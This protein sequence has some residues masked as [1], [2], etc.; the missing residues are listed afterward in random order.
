MNLRKWLV[1][2][3]RLSLTHQADKPYSSEYLS[4]TNVCR[5]V[6]F[7]ASMCVYATMYCQSLLSNLSMWL[8]GTPLKPNHVHCVMHRLSTTRITAIYEIMPICWISWKWLK[9]Q[10]QTMTELTRLRRDNRTSQWSRWFLSIGS[11]TLMFYAMQSK[12]PNM[13]DRR[14]V[15]SKISSLLL[16]NDAECERLNQQMI[17]RLRRQI[18]EN[19]FSIYLLCEMENYQWTV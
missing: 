18:D 16:F 8:P 19:S 13:V 6:V 17:G 14:R 15:C 7:A 12:Q 4:Y 3:N 11:S 9:R 10:R 1:E 2:L 5:A